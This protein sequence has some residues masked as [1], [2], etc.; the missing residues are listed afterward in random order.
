M[1]YKYD[2]SS[3]WRI[4]AASLIIL[5]LNTA[6]YLTTDHRFYQKWAPLT[7]PKDTRSG[8]K[9]YV[10]CTVSVVMKG[11]PMGMI[12]LAPAGSQN[13]DIEK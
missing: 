8:I 3:A 5:I 2:Y 9:G 6:I 12:S 10:K 13:D 11:D 7:D 1:L 4:I